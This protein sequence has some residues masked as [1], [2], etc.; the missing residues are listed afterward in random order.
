MTDNLLTR[1]L[2]AISDVHSDTSVSLEETLDALGELMDRVAM[3]IDAVE[4]D[5]RRAERDTND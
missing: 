3:L 1:A 2:A 5:I 4:E